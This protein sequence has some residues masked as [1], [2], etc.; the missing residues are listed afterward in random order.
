MVVFEMF[1]WWYSDGY[2]DL[3]IRIKDRIV[4][5]WHYFSV[6]LL[7]KTL[8]APW[9]RI[10]TYPGKSIQER[11][12]AVIDNL[13]SRLVGFF[14]RVLVIFVAVIVVIIAT[15]LGGLMVIAWP[16][17][18]ISVVVLFVMGLMP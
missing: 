4:R 17:A 16:F 2:R 12:R 11:L 1:R 13:V 5:V 3:L 14:V 6:A 8:F 15:L 18:P 10:I 7:V 9:K